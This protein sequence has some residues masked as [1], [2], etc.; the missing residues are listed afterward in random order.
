MNKTH[1]IAATDRQEGQTSEV[2]FDL[3]LCRILWTK[4]PILKLSS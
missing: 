2:P 4:T 1:V 3:T